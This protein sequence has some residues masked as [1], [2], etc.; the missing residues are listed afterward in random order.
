MKIPREAKDNPKESHGHSSIVRSGKYPFSFYI[1]SKPKSYLPGRF[2]EI[3]QLAKLSEKDKSHEKENVTTPDE[4]KVIFEAIDYYYA[5]QMKENF[6]TN[7]RHYKLE[8]AI[9]K[10]QNMNVSRANLEKTPSIL[11]SKASFY[12]LDSGNLKDKQAVVSTRSR[13]TSCCANELQL[14]E[15]SHAKL[16]R[17][18][19]INDSSENLVNTSFHQAEVVKSPINKESAIRIHYQNEQMSEPITASHFGNRVAISAKNNTQP[20]NDS[21]SFVPIVSILTRKAK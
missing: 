1:N 9:G 18:K 20:K 10:L 8:K 11:Q 19:I 7:M 6:E 12:Q 5:K 16:A 2:K 14:P 3:L 15:L 4:T 13:R 17:S 21:Y